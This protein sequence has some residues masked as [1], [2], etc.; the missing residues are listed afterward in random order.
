MPRDPFWRD[1]SERLTFNVDDLPASDFPSLCSR[2]VEMFDLVVDAMPI[3]GLDLL[4]I[5]AHH[6]DA[7]VGLDWDNWMGF[8]V[9]AKNR[10]AEDVV[11]KIGEWMMNGYRVMVGQVIV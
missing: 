1:A 8:M 9:V 10:E 3:I 5:E 2:I 11:R 7:I 6:G 4:S